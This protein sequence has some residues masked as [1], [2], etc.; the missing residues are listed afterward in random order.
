[1]L[2]LGNSCIGGPWHPNKKKA[3]TQPNGIS[4]GIKFDVTNG[5][6]VPPADTKQLGLVLGLMVTIARSVTVEL[7]RR[8][9]MAVNFRFDYHCYMGYNQICA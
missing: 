5:G 3:P 2:G 1:M 8:S 7:E 6:D 9:A 4:C